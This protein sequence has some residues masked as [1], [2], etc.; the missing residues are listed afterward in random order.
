MF[1]SSHL[2][3]FLGSATSDQH[4]SGVIYVAF[5]WL[6]VL[7]ASFSA[8]SL[9]ENCRLPAL[10]VTDKELGDSCERLGFAACIVADETKDNRL[11]KIAMYDH[12][13]FSKTLFLDADTIVLQDPT[14]GFDFLDYFDVAM[15]AHHEPVPLTK[16]P[17]LPFPSALFSS[18]N[19]GVVFFRKSVQVEK[20]FESWRNEY[21]RLKRPFDQPAL[22]GAVLE[23]SE[24]V[25]VLG[26]NLSWNADRRTA[27]RVFPRAYS[28]QVIDHYRLTNPM[29]RRLREYFH[30]VF[31]PELGPKLS[32]GE[33]RMVQEALNSPT[34]KVLLAVRGRKGRP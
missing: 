7:M 26:L 11:A 25:T 34:A 12:S 1:N 29:K 27:R 31:L 28:S 22:I 23:H 30:R 2:G 21:L 3:R 9:A 8:R 6:H 24:K 19:S 33:A 10:V 20:F 15:R 17:D 5:G 18:W 32:P 13:P 4:S 16:S 14:P